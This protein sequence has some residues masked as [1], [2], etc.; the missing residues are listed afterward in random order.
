[1]FVLWEVTSYV[2]P[3]AVHVWDGRTLVHPFS[4]INPRLNPTGSR[5]RADLVDGAS[6][7]QLPVPH[8]IIFSLVISIGVAFIND[9]N[10]TFFSAGA[11]FD[12]NG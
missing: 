2:E 12:L 8:E 9:G 4:V 7:F 10:I 5:G 3:W 6:R 1:V 11:D